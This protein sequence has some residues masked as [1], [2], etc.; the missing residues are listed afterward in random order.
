MSMGDDIF[1][2]P[3]MYQ[4]IGSM[5]MAP[6]TMPFGTGLYPGAGMYGGGIGTPSYLGN[7][8]MQGQPDQDKYVA[9]KMNERKERNQMKTALKVL[10]GLLALTF[11]GPICKNIR[12]V[13][14]GKFLTNQW[15]ATKKFFGFKPSKTPKPK[16]IG[17][18]RRW[19]RGVV[20]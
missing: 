4:D 5:S 7:V 13:G 14:I 19:A 10:G 6:M 17:R 20:F 8:R 9:M 2:T 18:F 16:S 15:T 1:S 3:I 12:K 11:V